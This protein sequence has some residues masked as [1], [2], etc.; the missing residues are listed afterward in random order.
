MIRG[1][2]ADQGRIQQWRRLNDTEWGMKFGSAG[3]RLDRCQ[4]G[5]GRR[6]MIT[7]GTVILVASTH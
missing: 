3:W 2:I 5:C 1:R 4:G 7:N 6:T